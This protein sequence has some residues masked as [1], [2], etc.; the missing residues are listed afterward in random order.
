MIYSNN[1][2]LLVDR[3]KLKKIIKKKY[4]H[5]RKLKCQKYGIWQFIAPTKNER[6]NFQPYTYILKNRIIIKY[7]KHNKS[8]ISLCCDTFIMNFI[9]VK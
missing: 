8:N 2:Y 1:I 3:R 7:N 6:K 4:F 9:S 5:Y